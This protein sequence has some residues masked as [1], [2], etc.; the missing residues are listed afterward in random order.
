VHFYTKCAVLCSSNCK[1]AQLQFTAIRRYAPDPA[2][3]L[4][5]LPQT[6][7]LDFEGEERARGKE[8]ERKMK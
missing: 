7:W 4:K 5:A 3:E 6:P 2:G 1:S 8:K